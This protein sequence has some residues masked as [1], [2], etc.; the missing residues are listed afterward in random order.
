MIEFTQRRVTG[1]G[2]LPLIFEE[3]KEIHR[4]EFKE[5]PAEALMSAM[6]WLENQGGA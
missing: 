5:T 6:M 3:G 2:W 1:Y 4:G